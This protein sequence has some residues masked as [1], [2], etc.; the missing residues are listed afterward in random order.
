MG[1]VEK[2]CPG[3]AGTA[4]VSRCTATG[5]CQHSTR[6]PKPLTTT[7]GGHN[8]PGDRGDR[9]R[10]L[11]CCSSRGRGERGAWPEHG[12]PRHHPARPRQTQQRNKEH[13]LLTQ[14]DFRASPVAIETRLPELLLIVIP[15]VPSFLP[16]LPSSNQGL[17][18]GAGSPPPAP[19]PPSRGSHLGDVALELG[20]LHLPGGLGL[21]ELLLQLASAA[22]LLPQLRAQLLQGHL[23]VRQRLDAL[24]GLPGTGGVS[25]GCR[26]CT[27][28]LHAATPGGRD[29]GCHQGLGSPRCPM[30]MPSGD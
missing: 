21:G 1:T 5:C 4:L 13:P 26:L 25:G 12:E 11:W 24:V 8:G 3:S 29:V 27:L 17:A 23:H 28:T 7:R 10:G 30:V 20:T 22:P 9:T 18:P 16:A 6:E 19:R 15:A 14:S 2:R